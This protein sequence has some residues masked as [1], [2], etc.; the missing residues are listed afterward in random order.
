MQ[1]ISLPE[2][3]E[4]R[5]LSR[6]CRLRKL[7][8]IIGSGAVARDPF[9]RTA[10]SGSSYRFFTELDRQG[11][12]ER[13]FGVEVPGLWR[14][15][16]MVRNIHPRRTVWREHFYMDVAYRRALTR[17]INKRLQPADFGSD[18]LQIGAMYHVPS[19]VQNNQCYSYHDGN[20]AELLRGSHVPKGLSAK[21]ID[22][23][24]AFE[25]QVCNGC[26]K[27]FTMSEYLRQ[28]FIHDYGMLP[29]RVTVIGA[30]INLEVIPEPNPDKRYDNREVLFIGVD[31]A[32]K[33]GWELLRAFRGI[34]TRFP[35]ARLHLVG[36]RQLAIPVQLEK[37]VVYH[38]FLHKNNPADRAK[39]LDLMGR[40]SLFV[41]PSLYEPFG[42]APLEAMVYQMPAL[43]TNGWALKELVTPG[44]TGDLVECGSVDDLQAKMQGLLSDPAG[45]RRMGAAGR[46]RVLEHYTWEKVI[47]RLKGALNKLQ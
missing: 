32:R 16:Y 25:K 46:Q 15:L 8:G 5:G 19:L 2:H 31:F 10:W 3:G 27:V 13:A 45:L 29:D 23:A 6:S 22:R 36:P 43:V 40:C 1:T 9:S 38:G 21:K 47:E 33:G 42:I 30:G 20:L 7:V 24:L 12:L 37:R 26:S 44:Q 14:Y 17:E 39:L 35:D 34:S 4:R 41:M 18:F 28:S 11:L